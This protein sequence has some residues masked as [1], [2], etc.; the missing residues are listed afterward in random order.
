MLQK[1]AQVITNPLKANNIPELIQNV[2]TFAMN[3]GLPIAIIF[4]VYSGF[5]FVSAKG[6]EKKLETAKEAFKW[7]VVG[8]ALIVG[9]DFLAKA[10]VNFAKGL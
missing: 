4:I 9:A 3:I 7:A 8:A 5:L 6:N 2:A 1:L 10:I